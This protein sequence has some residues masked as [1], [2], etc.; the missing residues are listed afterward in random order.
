MS[1]L[2]EIGW[3]IWD[4]IGLSTDGNAWRAGGFAD[5]YDSYLLRAAGMVRNGEAFDVIVDY[6]IEAETGQMGLSPAPNTRARGEA[7]V[8]A[9]QEDDQLWSEP[10]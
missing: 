6:L 2:R 3:S 7:V 9:I 1:R 4:P 10:S 5:E 8:R